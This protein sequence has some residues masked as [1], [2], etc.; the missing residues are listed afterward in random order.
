MNF[1]NYSNFNAPNVNK[2]SKEALIE[3]L[4]KYE[5]K[6][7]RK[8][9]KMVEGLEEE[10]DF[11]TATGLFSDKL[12]ALSVLKLTEAKPGPDP[13]MTGLDDETEEDKE[14]QMKK[15]TEMDDDD[16]EA[17]KEMPGD[18]EAREDGKVKTSKHTKAYDE[19]YGD[20][21]EN[22]NLQEGV[23]T[24]ALGIM[25]AYAGLKVLKFVAKKVV[26]AIGKNV[27]LEPSKLKKVSTE[28]VKRVA[29]ETNSGAHL[30]Y[31]IAL[32]REI[33]DKIDSGEIKTIRGIQKAMEDYLK[34][35]ESEI[36]ISKEDMEK[37]HKDGKVEVDGIEVEFVDEARFVKDFD[38]A[39]LDAKTKEDVLAIYPKAEFYIGKSDHFFGE[40]DDNLFFKAY[41][42]KAQKEFEIKSV[43]SEKGSN[44]VHLYNESVVTEAKQ[45]DLNFKIGDTVDL[46]GDTWEIIGTMKPNKKFSSPFT[47]R[48]KDMDQITIS[49]PTTSKEAEGYKVRTVEPKAY[50]PQYGFLYQYTSGGK[51]YTKLAIGGVSQNESVDEAIVNEAKI[52]VTKRDIKD[53]E[54][55]GNIDIAYKKAIALL[56]SLVESVVTEAKDKVDVSSLSIGNTYKDSKGYPVKVVDIKGTGNTWKVTYQYEDGKKKTVSTSLDKG[57]NLYESVVNENY[58]VIYSDGVSAMKKFRSEK[59]ALDFM[60]QTIASNKKL[61]DIAV[62]KPGMHS[63]T[64]TELVVKFWGDGSYL[65]NVSK[66]DPKLAAKK[67]E[68]GVEVSEGRI[69]DYNSPAMIAFRAAKMKR[70]KELAKPKRRP[71]YG[72]QR[73]KAEDDLWDISQELKGLYSDRGQLLIDMEQEAEPE[74]GPIADRYGAELNDIEDQIQAL[75]AKRGKLEVRLAESVSIN[76]GQ[77]SWF[78]QDSER[79]IGSEPENTINVYMYDN[80]GNQ[81]YEKEYEGYGEFGGMDYYELLARMN[82]YSDEDLKDKALLKSIRAISS[83]E[84]R[85]IGIALAFDTAKIKTRDK[86]GKVLYP[87][88]VED[89]KYN[90]K[91]HDFTKQPERD[92]NQ[93]WY[94]PEYDYYESAL[95]EGRAWGTFG[96]PE[97]KT[98]I[99][100]LEK[101]FAKFQADLEKAHNTYKAK[102]KEFTTGSKSEIGG[103]SGFHDSEGEQSV[104]YYTSQAIKNIFKLDDFGRYDSEWMFFEGLTWKGLKESLGIN[105]KS[106]AKIQKEWANV[107]AVMKDKVNVYKTA[108]G[109]EKED[110]LDE[111]KSLTIAK[112]KLEAELDKAVGLKD[113]DAGL[114]EAEDYSDDMSF[115]QLERCID[116]ST[117]IRERI[118][119]GTSLDP[120]M[121]SQIAVA[122]NELNSVFDALD[123]DDGVVE[124]V[125]EANFSY[126]EK[127]VRDVAEL[128]AK[129][130]SKMDKVKALVHDMEYDKGRGAGFEIS[131]NGDKYDGGSYSVR[132]NGDVVNDAISKVSPNAV[133]AK[134]GDTNINKVIKNIS[135]YESVDEAKNLDRE[136]MME[137]LEGYLDFV[138]ETE[139]FDGSEGGIWVS[140]ENGD[141]YKGRRI[142]DYYTED[143][144]N[145]EF[146]VYIP[147]AKEMR[148][149]GWYGEWHDA[150]TMMIWPD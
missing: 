7:P 131:I 117:M 43:Y 16:P 102:I 70:E 10:V 60:K 106:I 87:A 113:L 49:A 123:G 30:F 76:E 100:A 82:G 132:P 129:A 98:V 67:L 28:I 22:E 9:E 83:P 74:G 54:D 20:E 44:Y 150:G 101:A 72:K 124:S 17:Y 114:T 77:F 12:K 71:L 121:H 15:Q 21:E 110:L 62:Y 109:Q 133:Y 80:E 23:G 6:D 33:D 59:Q 13:Y 51:L 125:N 5:T 115:G 146:G 75:I 95:T 37:L 137:W 78:T 139:D 4:L 147:F 3:A 25:L 99:K 120:W 18:K 47:F 61:R 134:I 31:G 41:Y 103:K 105:E 81:W 63:T 57:I 135:K 36:T 45:Y 69:E 107:T 48:G 58:E 85:D 32:K 26:G 96:T 89:P 73:Q 79:Q 52:K 112:K 92:P 91:R 27:E 56:M 11:A 35:N 66:R 138:R 143:Y 130:I 140:G 108:E 149:R 144:K 24:V 119:A 65:D 55:S 86:G 97:A 118:Q 128:I 136:A 84:M 14:E 104:N 50:T 93:S 142:F 46:I 34:T 42:T 38:K 116:Y 127:E 122:E 88:L 141:T 126:S 145:Y 148:K 29:E 39:V 68:E 8:V 64:Q 94:T 111:L 2:V 53:I 1:V 90:W 40:L 19:L